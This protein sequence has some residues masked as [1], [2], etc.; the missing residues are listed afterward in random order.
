MTFQIDCRPLNLNG[1]LNAE[2]T[3]RD[4]GRVT[5]FDQLNLGNA[6]QRHRFAAAVVEKNPGVSIE[7]VESQLL[8]VSERLREQADIVPPIRR[9][10]ISLTS[11]ELLLETILKPG[12]SELQFAAYDVTSSTV[13]EVSEIEVGGLV[14]KPPAEFTDLCTTGF[15]QRSGAVLLSSAP[16]EYGDDAR[17]LEDV[18]SFIHRYIELSPKY[19][20]IAT[21]YVLFTWL[22]DRFDELPYLR[23]RNPEFGRG[24]SRALETV[25]SICYRPVFVAGGSSAAATRRIVDAFRGTLV[26]D[27]QDSRGDTDL[28]STMAKILN[29][30]FQR[31]R[32]LIYCEGDGDSWRPRK[33]EIFG[34]KILATRG[35]LGD[36]ATESRCLTIQIEQRTREDVPRNLPRHQFDTESLALRNKLLL[37]RF[38]NWHAVELDERLAVEGI[39]DRSNQIAVP[40]LSIV[41]DASA[42]A[43][44]VSLLRGVQREIQTQKADSWAGQIVEYLAYQW[45]ES[46]D[47]VPVKN[48]TLHLN[49]LTA[50]AQDIAVD[51]L[52]RPL[53]SQKVGR[54]VRE[55]LGLGTVRRG[56]IYQIQF[57][58]ERFAALQLRFLEVPVAPPRQSPANPDQPSPGPKS[59]SQIGEHVEVTAIQDCQDFRQDIEHDINGFRACREGFTNLDEDAQLEEKKR[60]LIDV[61]AARRGDEPRKEA[62]V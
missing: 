43:T 17:L 42:R 25:G 59:S 1:R 10:T 20:I 52:R 56:G 31:G 36:D 53:T 6:Q 34:P 18:R 11:D 9:N 14:V 38:R 62:L 22:Y 8:E 3:A 46:A 51:K 29:Q 57:S 28:T 30:G 44:I 13:S 15:G 7:E 58:A 24:K 47:E 50:E 48:V 49:G 60:S 32:P 23:F 45:T 41:R 5:Y 16:K 37:W 54:I 2:L 40:L 55:E 12:N 39:E 27:E 19:E 61:E 4:G 21:Y 35:R 26:A 33:F